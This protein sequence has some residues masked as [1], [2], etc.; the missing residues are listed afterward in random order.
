MVP[1]SF[2]GLA[3]FVLLLAPGFAYVL[4]VERSIPNRELS[5]FRETLHVVFVSIVC[6]FATGLLFAALRWLWPEHT[7]NIRGLIRNPEEF[8]REHHVQLAWWSI[9]FV[10]VATL[11]GAFVADPRYVDWMHALL[12]SR[13]GRLI[14]GSEDTDIRY[15]S[16]WHRVLDLYQEDQPGPVLVGVALD[17]GSRVRGRLW[18]YNP[19]QEEEENRD[20]VLTPPLTLTS[21]DGQE[22][23]L[24]TQFTIV[25]ARRIVRMDVTHLPPGYVFDGGR[26]RPPI[27]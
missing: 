21:A 14:T 24:E 11:L 17:D 19:T 4:R 6:L 10:T 7:L 12:S 23:R 20:L 18:A 9:A 26:W 16:Q 3:F 8:S 25:S 2:A 22:S 27:G 15:V 13:A 1:S 5:V